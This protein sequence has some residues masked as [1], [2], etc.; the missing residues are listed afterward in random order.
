MSSIHERLSL[1]TKL[2][3]QK[4]RDLKLGLIIL[5]VTRLDLK[6]VGKDGSD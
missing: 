4:H 6:K 2:V 3:P 5:H 1:F